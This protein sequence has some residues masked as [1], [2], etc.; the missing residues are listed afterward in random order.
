MASSAFFIPHIASIHARQVTAQL[1]AFAI[2]WGYIAV[3]HCTI[4]IHIMKFSEM[5]TTFEQRTAQRRSNE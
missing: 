2:N 1:I 3:A 4:H 5:R